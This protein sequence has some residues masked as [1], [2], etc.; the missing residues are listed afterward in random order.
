VHD[1]ACP[2]TGDRLDGRVGSR[3]GLV[4]QIQ[5]LANPVYTIH[6]QVDAFESGTPSRS[7]LLVRTTRGGTQ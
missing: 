5:L 6:L 3:F 1:E 2:A 4:V 7:Q